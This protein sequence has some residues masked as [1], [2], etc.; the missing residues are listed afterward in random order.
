MS[1]FSQCGDNNVRRLPSEI[2]SALLASSNCDNQPWEKIAFRAV[3]EHQYHIF[4]SEA[5]P[6][7]HVLRLDGV[8]NHS[9]LSFL[10]NLNRSLGTRNATNPENGLAYR[11][12]TVS[13]EASRSW[14]GKEG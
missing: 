14:G 2:P 9:P 1:G 3:P 12:G 13:R 5:T 11:S 7:N 6:A 4:H 10:E 8:A